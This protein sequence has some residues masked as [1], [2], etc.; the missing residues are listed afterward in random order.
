MANECGKP[1]GK[2]GSGN[3]GRFDTY[4]GIQSPTLKI[5]ITIE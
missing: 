2:I 1:D 5:R 4:M 3:H